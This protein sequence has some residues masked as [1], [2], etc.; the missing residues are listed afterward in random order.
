MGLAGL[1]SDAILSTALSSDASNSSRTPLSFSC[2][3]KHVVVV[4]FVVVVAA[5]DENQNQN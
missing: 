5:V 3:Q 2:E 4:A 1:A